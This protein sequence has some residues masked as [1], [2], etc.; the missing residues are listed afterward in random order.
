MI[1]DVRKIRMTSR[2]FGIYRRVQWMANDDI[3]SVLV[4]GWAARE[5]YMATKE[6]LV[7][8]AE[9]L[10]DELEGK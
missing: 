6:R 9:R 5:N 2:L 10:L 4:N 1:D 7:G 8:E 3:R